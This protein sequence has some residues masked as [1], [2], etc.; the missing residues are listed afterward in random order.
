MSLHVTIH[1]RDGGCVIEVR[2]DADLATVEPLREAL[3]EVLANRE[4]PVAVDLRAV[5]LLDSTGLAALL[6]AQRRLTRAKRKL[7]LIVTPGPV[8]R[9]LEV[10]K[11]DTTFALADTPTEALDLP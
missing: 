3:A 11:L 8:A 1:D 4:G 10:S 6:N 7:S 2:G 5:T 9:V